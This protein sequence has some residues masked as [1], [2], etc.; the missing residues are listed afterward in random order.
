MTREFLAIFC[1]CY[2][3]SAVFLLPVYVF[4]FIVDPGKFSRPLMHKLHKW[5]TILTIC[6]PIL[7]ALVMY[8][9]G[10]SEFASE[11]EQLRPAGP[12]RIEAT[13]VP[14]NAGEDGVPTQRT[15]YIDALQNY[16]QMALGIFYYLVD[17]VAWLSVAG[18][19]VFLFRLMV[20]ILYIGYIQRSSPKRESFN[21][22][23]LFTSDKITLP[24]STGFGNKKVFLPYGLDSVEK[25]II[26]RHELNHFRKNH[27]YWSQLESLILHLFWFNPVSHLMR[28]RGVL[29]RE[30]ECDTDTV[31][32]VDKFIY[33]RVLVKT[34]ESMLPSGRFG[35]MVQQWIQKGVLKKRLENILNGKNGR[36]RRLIGLGFFLVLTF[37]VGIFVFV[38]LLDDENLEKNL[39]LS[40]K[41]DYA[42]IMRSRGGIKIDDVP[43]HLVTVL[44][45]SEDTGFY[46]H[47]GINVKAIFRAMI[48]NLSVG[49]FQQGAS[50]ITQ[51]LTR[52]FGVKR[53]RSL[54]RKLKEIK[55]AQVLE[56]HFSKDQILE[57]YLNSVY[58]GQGA[59]GVEM[60]SQTYFNHPA[61]ELIVAESAMLVQ[62][63]PKPSYHNCIA[64]P[65]VGENRTMR[66]L[67]RMVGQGLIDR[68]TAEQSLV[69][70]GKR[71]GAKD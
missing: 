1:T 70:L 46:E 6:A 33:S 34:A 10:S 30:M 57:M 64:N 29:F 48:H 61:S 23:S 47:N 22:Y 71:L 52:Q 25:D 19:V 27:H 55:A 42:S 68:H 69:C 38:S 20:Q 50:T 39:V 32:T 54:I 13:V 41:K 5:I 66:L 58:F 45:F 51:Q 63:L 35:L 2:L 26:L 14:R 40:V 56:R 62:S 7:F 49:G 18:L 53:E 24:F 11:G 36:K 67:N 37:S 60:A 9:S 3:Y 16:H 8:S 59:F 28:K 31:R 21:R 15:G 65:E 12:I 4:Y 17:I 44:I 43:D